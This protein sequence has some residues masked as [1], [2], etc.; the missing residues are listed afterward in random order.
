MKESI[1]FTKSQVRLLNELRQKHEQLWRAD[2]EI[3]LAMIYEEH[4][5]TEKSKDGK[6]RFELQPGFAGVNVSNIE[7][8]PEIPAVRPVKAKKAKGPTPEIPN[9]GQK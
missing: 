4:G 9:G 5:L 3:T 1:A 7:P 6:H 2:L 8:K